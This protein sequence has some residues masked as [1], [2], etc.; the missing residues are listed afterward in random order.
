MSHRAYSVF[1]L[2]PV[3][4]VLLAPV[5]ALAGLDQPW[6]EVDDGGNGNV[7]VGMV[8]LGILAFIVHLIEK[9]EFLGFLKDI[10]KGLSFLATIYLAGLMFAACIVAIAVL[11][12]TIGVSKDSAWNIISLPLGIWVALMLFGV[13]Q[14]WR[15]PKP[16]DVP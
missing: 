2:A 1:S 15:N 11:L 9:G 8:V 10:A 16:K 12:Q 4:F 7:I 5:V 6:N 14:D 13:Y 3:V